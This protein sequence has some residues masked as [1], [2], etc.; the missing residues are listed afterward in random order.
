MFFQAFG[1]EGTASLMSAQA[2]VM[3]GKPPL[4]I[5]FGNKVF[6]VGEFSAFEAYVDHLMRRNLS[7]KIP[8]IKNAIQSAVSNCFTVFEFINRPPNRKS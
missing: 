6:K 8:N 3:A 4:A 2:Y 5:H 7:I 1:L